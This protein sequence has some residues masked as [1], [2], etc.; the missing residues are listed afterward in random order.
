MLNA[1][2]GNTVVVQ[3]GYNAVNAAHFG[4]STLVD[5]DDSGNNTNAINAAIKYAYKLSPASLETET[6]WQQEI[7]LPAGAD[8]RMFGVIVVPS[9]IILNLNG[10]RLIGN[11]GSGAT[12]VYS[13][14]GVHSIQSGYYDSASDNIVSN[15]GSALNARRVTNAVIKN[16]GFLNMNCALL[17][18]MNE[19]CILNRFRIELYKWTCM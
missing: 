19:G 11:Y 12:T 7:I 18:N 2:A 1:G 14:G 8:C 17:T 13:T 16:G 9:G 15:A 4:F 6:P 3:T 5:A 10:G